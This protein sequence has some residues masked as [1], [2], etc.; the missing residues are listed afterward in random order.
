[1]VATVT[2]GKSYGAAHYL[3]P[4]AQKGYGNVHLL[5][6]DGSKVSI[7]VNILASISPF[8][9]DLLLSSRTP[10]EEYFI[11]TELEKSE[12][13]L[14]AKFAK[15]GSVSGYQFEDDLFHDIQLVNVFAYFGIYL[16]ELNF[17]AAEELLERK[18][19]TEDDIVIPEFEDEWDFLKYQPDIKESSVK[20]LDEDVETR[21]SSRKRKMVSYLVESDDDVKKE[22]PDFLIED[23][24]KQ[25]AKE[26]PVEEFVMPKKTQES[27]KI[28]K[29]QETQRSEQAITSK[30][31]ARRSQG[32][33]QQAVLFPSR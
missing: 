13:D 15:C 23:V 5:A 21:R 14:F 12:L 30:A 24:I 29:D 27:N 26:E 6:K 19:K 25:E 4:E 8:C 16:S 32:N 28:F 7:N 20:K 9:Y 33:G 11:S 22:D 3:E 17:S 2:L 31:L 1:M 10:D 18:I